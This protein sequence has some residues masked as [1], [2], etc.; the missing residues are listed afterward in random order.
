[1]C[2][3]N[4]FDLQI[5]DMTEMA[6]LGIPAVSRC[7]PCCLS[8]APA[9]R[10]GRSPGLTPLPCA[11]AHRP[12]PR[13]GGPQNTVGLYR[14][15][16]TRNACLSGYDVATASATPRPRGAANLRPGGTVGGGAAGRGGQQDDGGVYVLEGKVG[17][18]VS[19]WIRKLKSQGG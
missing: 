2:S 14:T 6:K 1:M 4:V 16:F 12:A 7:A 3:C 19:S 10:D 5:A 17:L 9:C 8:T 15:N 13:Y 11:A 18:G